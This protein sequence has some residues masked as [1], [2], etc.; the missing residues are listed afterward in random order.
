MGPIGPCGPLTPTAVIVQ[1]DADVVP[2]LKSAAIA[3]DVPSV[4]VTVPS[5]KF[6]VVL[7][8]RTLEPVTNAPCL[9][10]VSVIIPVDAGVAV[11]IDVTPS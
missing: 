6:T 5:K 11:V 9:F 2:I 1:E 7:A 3:N 10:V 4:I 8:A